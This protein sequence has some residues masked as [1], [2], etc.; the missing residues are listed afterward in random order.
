MNFTVKQIADLLGGEVQG[1]AS[2]SINKLAKID[3]E[4]DVGS[5]CFLSNPKYENYLYQTKATAII[6]KKD[7]TPKK[8][9][10]ATLILV[11]DPYLAFTQLLEEYDKII[12]SQK[13]DKKVGIEQ[14][15]VLGEGLHQGEEVYI[16]AF[17]YV[18]HNCVIGN[19]VKIYPQS[20]IGDNVIIGDHTV[21]HPGVKIYANT[22]I[23]QHCTI[24]SGAV[25]GSEG[26]GF[27]PQEDGTYKNIPQ[28]GQ[29][30]LEDYVNVGANTTIDRATIGATL[31]QQGVKLDNLIQVG[32]NVVIGKNT[33]MAAQS[34]IAGSSKLGQGCIV[35]GQ[36][37][38]ANSI[39]VSDYVTM[40]AKAGVNSSIKK[41]KAI[42]IGSPAIDAS[43]F[44]K[45]SV[46]FRRLPELKKKVDQLEEK[47]KN[48]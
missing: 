13:R 17:T 29:V 15:V 39:Q 41:E 47:L 40:G 48:S 4:A 25:L 38:I 10:A 33:V 3:E 9:V 8:S 42:V 18:G 12:T 11:D 30:I 46:I 28:L 14:P 7:F 16:G 2:L 35:A 36:V 1:D 32:H 44:W 20:Y 6:V 43:N 24:H 23:G 34:G 45:S 37:G 5:I 19:H 22:H 26:F 31:I 27:A 21:I